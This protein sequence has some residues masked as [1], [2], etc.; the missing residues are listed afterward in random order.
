M[1]WERRLRWA[2]NGFGLV[3]VSF[4]Q[5]LVFFALY[6]LYITKDWLAT[7]GYR[8]VPYAKRN[9]CENPKPNLNT[10]V[11]FNV[12]INAFTPPPTTTIQ[13][14]SISAISKL[15]LTRFGGTLNLGSWEHLEQIP[16]VTVIFVQA[17]FV[18][19]TFAYIINI[20]NVTDP[21]L[22]KL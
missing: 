1:S 2:C 13:R 12:K 21:I 4:C 3:L 10:A 11:G 6:N 18:L 15:L 7:I 20:S 22:M 14:N 9:H 5:R 16:T 17:K 8:W 19:V